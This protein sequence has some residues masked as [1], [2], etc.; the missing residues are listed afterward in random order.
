MQVANLT[1]DHKKVS[2]S[3]YIELMNKKYLL[4]NNN[5][6]DKTN[7]VDAYRKYVT[8]LVKKHHIK[9]YSEGRTKYLFDWEQ[10]QELQELTQSYFLNKQRQNLNQKDRELR[11]LEI[12]RILEKK[13]KCNCKKERDKV[14]GKVK[15]LTDKEIVKEEDKLNRLVYST[16]DNQTLDPV[17]LIKQ[18]L[19]SE[20][21]FDDEFFKQLAKALEK[22]K[23]ETMFRNATNKEKLLGLNQMTYISDYLKMKLYIEEYED[24]YEV[25]RFGFSK[26]NIKLNNPFQY[27]YM[28]KVR[29]DSF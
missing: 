6:V 24:K 23:N 20:N 9:H 21:R 14:I 15:F 2:I 26:Y 5:D 1:N 10:I 7:K 22:L 29:V 18:R 8:K 27:Y 19:E 13:G 12:A 3:D 28:Q 11:D 17:L 16:I 25:I 4:F